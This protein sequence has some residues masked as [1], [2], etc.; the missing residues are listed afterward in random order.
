MRGSHFSISLV[1]V[2]FCLLPPSLCSSS[3]MSDSS[4]QEDSACGV[5]KTA[6]SLSEQE[7]E[8]TATVST[9]DAE[10]RKAALAEAKRRMAAKLVKIT[11]GR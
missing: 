4:T 3:A 6:A 11:L 8:T 5:P 9:E 7:V 1:I 10:S 2:V